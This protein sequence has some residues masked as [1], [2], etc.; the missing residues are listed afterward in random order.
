M[1]LSDYC[2]DPLEMFRLTWNF[3]ICLRING[4]CH[5]ILAEKIV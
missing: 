5:E 3:H 2:L 1:P 4:A